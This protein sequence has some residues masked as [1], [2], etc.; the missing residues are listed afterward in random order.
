VRQLYIFVL[1]HIFV[2]SA[3]TIEKRT[4][5]KGYFIQWDKNYRNKSSSISKD[6]ISQNMNGEILTQENGLYESFASLSLEIQD[7]SIHQNQTSAISERQ[8]SKTSN[9]DV[10]IKNSAN[11]IKKQNN[12]F[13]KSSKHPKIKQ[14][15]KSLAKKGDLHLILLYSLLLLL[16]GVLLIVL[17][18]NSGVIL[19]VILSVIGIFSIVFSIIFFL[20]YLIGL[21][22]SN[23]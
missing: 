5:N 3:C 12:Y 7:N 14:K 4:F 23:R 8:L 10:N 18:I 6:S 19:G 1:L 11:S 22:F 13:N 9:S 2:F 16:L 20:V 17:G 15:K 21:A